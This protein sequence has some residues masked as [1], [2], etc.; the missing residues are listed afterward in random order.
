MRLDLATQSLSAETII[1]TYDHEQLFHIF[2][3]YAQEHFSSDLATIIIKKRQHHPIKSSQELALIISDFY[4]QHRTNP[5]INPA[6]K[7][8]MALRIA[9]NQEYENLTDALMAIEKIPKTIVA[10]ITFHSGEDRIVKNYLKNHQQTFTKIHQ[11]VHPTYNEV[12]RNPLARSAILRSYI[13]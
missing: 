9:T 7:I 2:S 11:P 8:L 3:F 4:H 12:K 1:N 6:T 13:T 5:K 10:V